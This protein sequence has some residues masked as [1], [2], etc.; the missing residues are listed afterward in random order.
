MVDESFDSIHNVP[1]APE[2]VLRLLPKAF[3]QD[4]LNLVC[5]RLDITE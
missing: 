3:M 2:K 1:D 4:R 5:G